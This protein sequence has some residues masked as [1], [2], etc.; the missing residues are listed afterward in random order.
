M[1]LHDC[2]IDVNG[3]SL[4]L[5]AS[6][7]AWWPAEKTLVFAD[8]HLEKGSAYARGGQLLP[9]YDT[10]TTIRRMETVIAR[11]CPARA[12]AL[13][14]SFHDG[15]AGER[16]DAEECAKL[17]ALTGACDWLWVEGNHDPEPPAWLGGRITPEVAIGGLLFRHLPHAGACA[18]EVAGHLHPAARISRG[19]M[20][21]RRR[22][23]VSDGVRLLLPAFGAYTGGLDVRDVAVTCLFA[24][25]FAVYA[26]G[27]E[28]VYLVSGPV[29]AST[30]TRANS[31]S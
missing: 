1:T 29:Q 4:V 6:G 3:E 22:C 17:K 10:R 13:G 19:G 31:C 2:R 28:K 23:F 12:I 15:A 24:G 18:G 14:D 20:S 16:L 5:D 7:A 30:T 26:M 11:R 27:R 9:P 25:G 8:L 21:T